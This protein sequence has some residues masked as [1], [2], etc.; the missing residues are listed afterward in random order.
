MLF[1]FVYLADIYQSRREE[2][3]SVDS[4]VVDARAPFDIPNKFK[5]VDIKK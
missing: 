5:M 3:I 1:L 4:V 2:R